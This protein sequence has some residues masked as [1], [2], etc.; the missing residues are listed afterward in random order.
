V[1]SASED[2]ELSS[3]HR[4]A[5]FMR[6]VRLAQTGRTA[7]LKGQN[8]L[9]PEQHLAITNAVSGSGLVAAVKRTSEVDI[10]VNHLAERFEELCRRQ[11]TQVDAELRPTVVKLL[12]AELLANHLALEVPAKRLIAATLHQGA[13][14]PELLH[15]FPELPRYAIV[16]A[17][18]F[19]PEAPREFLRSAK[20]EIAIVS[21]EP[22][23][24]HLVRTQPSVVEQTV[25]CKRSKAR[26]LLRAINDKFG[27]GRASDTR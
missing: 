16:R 6:E 21:S 7:R 10:P 15:E 9:A 19:S 14:A 18:E 26:E 22:E 2:E 13:I 5:A 25:I 4:A 1:S 11:G 17:V 8:Y 23:F 20:R 24:Q 27:D 3:L 12:A